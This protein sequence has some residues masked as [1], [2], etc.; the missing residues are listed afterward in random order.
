MGI[1][2]HPRERVVP[3][4][5]ELKRTEVHLQPSTTW[6][7]VDRWKKGNGDGLNFMRL[8]YVIA[9][10]HISCGSLDLCI[11]KLGGTIQTIAL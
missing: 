1:V 7:V 9:I 2:C 6:E 4:K 3:R 5:V 8:A 11:K 10:G